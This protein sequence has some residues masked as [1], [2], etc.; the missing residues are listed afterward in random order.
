MCGD[1]YVWLIF[2]WGAFLQ[3][4]LEVF[5]EIFLLVFKLVYNF[6]PFYFSLSLYFLDMKVYFLQG[7]EIVF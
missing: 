2:V 7:T 3:T 5:L 4:S 6:Y 1:Y